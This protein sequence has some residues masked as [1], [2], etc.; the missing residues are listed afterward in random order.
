M[1]LV[2]ATPDDL[3]AWTG[4]QA[5]TN[6]LQLL[7]S[8]SL[9]V[10]EATELCYYPVDG[11]NM[12]TDATQLQAFNDATC[13]QAA[14]LAALE[15]DPTAG[16]TIV[17]DVESSVKLG[18][19]SVSYADADIAAQAKNQAINGLVNDAQRILR[20]AQITPTVPWVTG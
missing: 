13:C 4:T 20:D 10:R 12:P 2:Y 18:S 5:P 3:A 9:A 7:R 11:N 1:V 15:V 8:A 17:P 19:A 16:G 14:A 6:A